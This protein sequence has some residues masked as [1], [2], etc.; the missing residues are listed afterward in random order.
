[1]ISALGKQGKLRSTVGLGRRVPRK[2][3][4]DPVSSLY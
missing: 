1:M 3:R 4:D 2:K